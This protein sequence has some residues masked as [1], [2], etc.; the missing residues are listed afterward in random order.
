MKKLTA[1]FL[2]VLMFVSLCVPAGAFGFET[3]E[4]VTENSASPAESDN[5]ALTSDPLL[6]P[7]L[8]HHHRHDCGRGF[9]S[10]DVG[11]ARHYQLE[12]RHLARRRHISCLR[13]GPCSRQQSRPQLEQG[14]HHNLSGILHCRTHGKRQKV[15][16]CVQHVFRCCRSLVGYLRMGHVQ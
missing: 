12:K 11:Q 1:L 15:C 10:M 9:R 14:Q 4:T 3:V 13:H 5:T 8:N 7:G 2:S 16:A 6:K